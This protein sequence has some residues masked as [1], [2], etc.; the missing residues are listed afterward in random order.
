MNAIHR[1]FRLLRRRARG[2]PVRYL[3]VLAGMLFSISILIGTSILLERDKTVALETEAERGRLLA[4]TL[5]SHVSRTL[6]AVDNALD[7]LAHFIEAGSDAG[8]LVTAAANGSP[9]LRSISVLD[10]GGRVLTSSNA[11]NIGLR[12]DLSALGFA[13]EIAGALDPGRP[14]FVRDLQDLVSGSAPPTDNG[15]QVLPFA[16]AV[17]VNG[18][19]LVLLAMVNPAALFPDYRA[20]LGSEAGFAALF[21]YQGNVLGASAQA[22]YALGGRYA[23]LPMFAALQADKEF[24]R[25]RAPNGAGDAYLVNFR[26]ARRY[27]L[28]AVIGMPEAQVIA[29]WEAGSRRL[30]WLGIAAACFVLLYTVML[31]RVML[32][33]EKIERELKAAKDAAEQANAARGVFLS[34]MS[35]EIRTPMN[36]VIGMADLLRDTPLDAEQGE[37]VKAIGE[38][39]A[40]LLGIIDDVLDF[41]KIDAGRMEIESVD[42]DLRAV[43]EGSLDMVAARARQKNLSLL[44]FVDPALPA[45]VSADPVRLRQV[46]LNLAGNAVKFTPA[47][48]IMLSVRLLGRQRDHC[49]VRFEVADTG[50]GIERA[51]AARL[52][53]PFT[54]ADS[55]VTRQ[56][57]GTGLGLSICKRLVGMMGGQIA[58]DSAP[59]KGSTFRFDLSLP[60]R[61]AAPYVRRAN[62][63][64]VVLVE[65]NPRQSAILRAYLQSRGVQVTCVATGVAA[66]QLEWGAHGEQVAIVSARL[67]D[68]TP[69]ELSGALAAR[70]AQTRLVLLADHEDAR[71][72]AAAN[73]FHAA[74]LQPVRQAALFDAIDTTSGR[75][76]IGRSALPGADAER[77]Q[78]LP[79]DAGQAQRDERLI[80]L[81]EDNPTNQMVALRQLRQLGYAAHIA[82]NGQE[83]LEALAAFPYPLVL[84]DC[85][86]PVLDGFEAT[87][88]IRAQERAS[89]RRRARIIAMTANAMQGDRERCLEAGMDDYLAK[90]IL[91][92]QLAERLTAARATPVVATP[93]APGM[94]DKHDKHIAPML[95]EARLRDLFG[96]DAALRQEMLEL[97]VS[98]TQPVFDQLRSAIDRADFA[99]VHAIGHR[100]AGSC[101]NMGMDELAALAREIERVGRSGDP[102]GME[103]MHEAATAAFARLRDFVR[104]EESLT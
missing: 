27:P 39:A 22:P 11:G 44:C 66:L 28:A 41:S 34:T 103:E 20:A 56:Y 26:A 52:F 36:A 50:I 92:E 33:R 19:R 61:A 48:E 99:E 96:D 46:L 68:M 40:T 84:M 18:K 59:G 15:N 90:P 35:H 78:A 57:G 67:E 38:S 75:G 82:N 94:Y 30:K 79:V 74:L 73:G 101:G 49:M 85:Q 37:Y 65:P 81:V 77:R 54:Q 69:A 51:A 63:A 104:R 16:R 5:E 23:G 14:Q 97:F 7:V 3:F 95:D 72:D 62:A 29:Q 91:R 4:S 12:L 89:G 17:E 31:H 10:S 25:F 43:A 21:D 86:M 70:A 83:A 76:A 58:L 6:A 60:A 9:H 93:E 8:R 71:D 13:R 87:R 55:S 32:K 47:G 88:R 98:S 1:Q 45:V 100:L 2:F 53:T 80:L 64:R 24:G 42:C 102:R